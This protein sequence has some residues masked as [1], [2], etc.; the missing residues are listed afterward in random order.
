MF[1]EQPV[2]LMFWQLTEMVIPE[3]PEDMQENFSEYRFR[4]VIPITLHIS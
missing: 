3:K 1:T 4:I 2:D